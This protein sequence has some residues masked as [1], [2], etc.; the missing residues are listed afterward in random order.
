MCFYITS[1]EWNEEGHFISKTPELLV[2][3]LPASQFALTGS[4]LRLL[5]FH[6]S[7]C[8]CPYVSAQVEDRGDCVAMT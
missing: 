6:L 8:G 5:A 1:V 2:T 4:T 7:S 3:R